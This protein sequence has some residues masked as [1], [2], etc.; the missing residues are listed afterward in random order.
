MYNKFGNV[1]DVSDMVQ[2]NAGW[3]WNLEEVG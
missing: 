3:W 1:G 2:V